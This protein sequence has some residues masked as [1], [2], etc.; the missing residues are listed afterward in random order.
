MIFESS[1]RSSAPRLARRA[2][3]ST[4]SR[5]RARAARLVVVVAR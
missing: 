4:A 2:R 1:T 3:V 5:A